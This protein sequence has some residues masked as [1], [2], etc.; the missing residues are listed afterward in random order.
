MRP[1]TCVQAYEELRKLLDGGS[2]SMTHQ[3]AVIEFQ[4]L[5][6]VDDEVRAMEIEGTIIAAAQILWSIEHY[7]GQPDWIPN[8]QM[9]A[10]KLYVDSA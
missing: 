5:Q 3:D 9:V 4:R 1:S 7:D 10:G 8:I 2:E 6:A